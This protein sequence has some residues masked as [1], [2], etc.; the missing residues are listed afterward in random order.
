MAPCA[1]LVGHRGGAQ[2][3]EDTAETDAALLL[4]L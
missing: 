2:A 1:P 3:A 4:R